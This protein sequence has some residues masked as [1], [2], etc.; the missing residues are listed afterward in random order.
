MLW[1]SPDLAVADVSLLT[2]APTFQTRSKVFLVSVMALR[3]VVFAFFTAA[4][5]ADQAPVSLGSAD[6]F[7]VLAGSTVTSTGGTTVGNLAVSPGSDVTGFPPGTVNGMMHVSDSVAV[8]AQADLTTAYNDAAGRTLAPVS[9]AGNL[10]GLTLTPGLYKSTSGLEISSGELTLDAR[11]DVNAVFIFQMASTLV[12]STG[13]QVILIGGALAANIY[14]QVGTSATLGSSSVFKGTILADQSITLN[15]GATLEGRALARIGAVVLN[16]SIVNLPFAPTVPGPI[17]FGPIH[18]EPGGSATLVI[19]NT[20]GLTLTLQASSDLGV[21]TT[22]ATP[23][24]F[25]SP[26]VFIDTTASGADL[27]FYRAFY[28]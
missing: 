3:F 20:P 24:P 14:W 12:T 11:G 23:T 17:R 8:Q 22:L 2:S 21:W 4:T 19:T 28:P 5:M 27:R 13:R 25:V 7:T 10:G 15:S 6:G 18:R 26:D 1:K 16:A 9:V